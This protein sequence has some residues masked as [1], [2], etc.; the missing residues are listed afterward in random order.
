[1]QCATCQCLVLSQDLLFKC[2][3]LATWLFVHPFEGWRIPF[4]FLKLTSG[5]QSTGNTETV[6]AGVSLQPKTRE[7]QMRRALGGTVQTA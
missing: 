4:F 5:P 6:H 1:M 3:F 7:V 2:D